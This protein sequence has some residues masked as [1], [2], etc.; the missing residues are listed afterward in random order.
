VGAWTG[1]TSPLS[2]QELRERS[3]TDVVEFL[4]GWQPSGEPM[5]PSPEGL[6]R[7]LTGR[8]AA[9]PS[10]FA[11]LT[12]AIGQLDPTYVRASIQGFEKAAKDGRQLEWA[13]VI[14]LSEVAARGKPIVDSEENRWLDRDAGW[15]WARGAVAD[16]LTTA[17]RSETFPDGLGERAW[18]LL[19]ELSWDLD[20]TPEYEQKYG[21]SNM[22]PLTLSLNTTR[23]KAM[24]G[25][26]AFALWRKTRA[27][28]DGFSL[29]DIPAVAENL[30]RHL[31]PTREASETVR[32]VF[33]AS[34]NQLLWLDRDWVSQRISAIFPPD[35]EHGPLRRAAWESY[36]SYGGQP[37]HLFPLLEAEYNRAICELTPRE[38]VSRR[39]RRGPGS[40]LAEHLG[41]L[42]YNDRID[43]SPGGLME[44]F[45]ERARPKERS[46]LVDFL[47]R[48]LYQADPNS[49][50][51]EVTD[52]MMALWEWIQPKVTTADRDT[53]LRDFGWWYGASVLDPD[54]RNQQL[55]ALLRA[56]V[57]VEPEFVLVRGFTQSSS[58]DLDATLSVIYVYVQAERD[59]WRL[60]GAQDELRAILHQGTQGSQAQREKTRDVISLLAARGLAHFLDL[61][62]D[63][64]VEELNP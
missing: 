52:R 47:G 19:E 28:G 25:V 27:N 12:G 31:D 23:G 34:L 2:E 4:A 5:S 24:H 38:D 39:T 18:A 10:A 13:P 41:I 35:E 32:G 43:L 60:L 53:V 29:R 15:R 33:G 14:G 64:S 8:V 17:L 3:A 42:Y 62:S 40:V 44:Q 20:P 48:S 7:L 21:G 57:P 49:V 55:I 45:F 22:D 50:P 26:I 51:T 30:D 58:E 1:P 61:L 6:A 56:K 63:G 36:L 54:W 11:E 46:H 59:H 16:V 37:F 9:E